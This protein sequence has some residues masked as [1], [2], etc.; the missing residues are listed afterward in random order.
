MCACECVH[1]RVRVCVCS[2]GAPPKVVVL[3]L[4]S[5]QAKV[6]R[7]PTRQNK[8]KSQ[9]AL[10]ASKN[11]TILDRSGTPQTREPL[12]HGERKQGPRK[13]K[14]RPLTANVS[15]PSCQQKA[16]RFSFWQLQTRNPNMAKRYRAR[17]TNRPTKQP[18]SH[19]AEP[20]K[21]TVLWTGCDSAHPR[22]WTALT[23]SAP[24]LPGSEGSNSDRVSS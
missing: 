11:K 2:I 5:L 22:R 4:D 7:V 24:A 18:P 6:K 17:P 14:N 21:P 20:D 23:R 10:R 16:L 9:K 8:P 19:R 15:S 3:P 13:S 1:V 12:L